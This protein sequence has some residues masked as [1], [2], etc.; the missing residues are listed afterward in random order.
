MVNIL[1]AKHQHVSIDIVTVTES[2]SAVT[3]VGGGNTENS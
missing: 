2:E 3:V 1:S